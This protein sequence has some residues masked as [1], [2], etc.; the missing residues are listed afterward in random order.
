METKQAQ[1]GA[2]MHDVQPGVLGQ[3]EQMEDTGQNQ[4]EESP[5]TE[6][7]ANSLREMLLMKVIGTQALIALVIDEHETL[8][9]DC[10]MLLA[11][12]PL[13]QF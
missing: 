5:F 9:T 13:C 2:P 3:E 4:Q 8:L 10:F 11:H 1:G 7:G 6:P 12:L